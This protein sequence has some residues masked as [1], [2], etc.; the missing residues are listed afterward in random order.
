M[1]VIKLYTKNKPKKNG[2]KKS[3][4]VVSILLSFFVCVLLEDLDLEEGWGDLLVLLLLL[5]TE[6]E[7]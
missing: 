5:E 3:P 2:V 1:S 4:N 6:Y 7:I